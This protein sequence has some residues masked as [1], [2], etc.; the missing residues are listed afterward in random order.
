MTNGSPDNNVTCC[1]GI[2]LAIKYI[3]ISYNIHVATHT[4]GKHQLSMKGIHGYGY[5]VGVA[6]CI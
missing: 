3:I 6:I 5:V 4:Q 1:S 2:S